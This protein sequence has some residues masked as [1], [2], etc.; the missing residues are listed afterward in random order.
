MKSGT[1]IKSDSE[2]NRT[3]KLRTVIKKAESQT[4]DSQELRT[5]TSV[6]IIG[7]SQVLSTSHSSYCWLCR[8]DACI[9]S[10]LISRGAETAPMFFKGMHL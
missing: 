1:V 10:T 2:K 9:T 5:A 6:I 3:V 4:S 8:R 7:Q